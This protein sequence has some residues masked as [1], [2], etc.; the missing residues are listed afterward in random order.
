MHWPISIHDIGLVNIV[1][2]VAVIMNI[3]GYLMKTMIPLRMVA[4]T[5]NCLFI[6][7]STLAAVYPTLI[8]NFILL[9]INAMRFFQMKRL[10]RQVNEAATGDLSMDWLKPFTTKRH[11]AAGTTLFRKGDAATELHFII[12]GR[13]RVVERNVDIGAGSLI[14]EL[15]LL[16]PGKSRTATIECIESGETLAIAYDNVMQLYFQNPTFG[17]YFLQLSTARLF[18]TIKTLEDENAALR[19]ANARLGAAASG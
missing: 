11:F 15:G 18:H 4:M 1:A 17:F 13:F 7:Y 2:A 9:P 3:I 12:S 16:E 6:V 14:G 10:I 8:L 5:T 19:A